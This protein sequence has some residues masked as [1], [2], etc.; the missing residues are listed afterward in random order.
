MQLNRVKWAEIALWYVQ[1]DGTS[2]GTGGAGL[3]V[4]R[5]Q[6]PAA[7]TSSCSSTIPMQT[8]IMN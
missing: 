4:S 3:G 5:P 7:V 2:E 6:T 1:G 8:H